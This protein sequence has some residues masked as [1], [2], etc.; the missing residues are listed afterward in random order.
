MRSGL[1]S[2]EVVGDELQC[3]AS[4]GSNGQSDNMN[5]FPA[6]C[7]YTVI[8][9]TLLGSAHI[10]LCP[11]GTAT[12]TATEREDDFQ[13]NIRPMLRRYCFDC[14]GERR[15][16][17]RVNLSGFS[18]WPELMALA[19]CQPCQLQRDERHIASRRYCGKNTRSSPVAARSRSKSM[20]WG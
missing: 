15:E 11:E 17:G 2:T 12:E 6:L 14:H 18:S 16:E 8:G 10:V 19:R 4:C 20:A 5:A 3:G 13:A 7:S 9:W 1:T